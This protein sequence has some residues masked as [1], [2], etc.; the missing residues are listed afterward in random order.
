M[1][2]R[3]DEVIDP[4]RVDGHAEP[5]LRLDLVAFG[6]RD[7]THVVAEAGEL[8][9]ADLVP[10]A[11]ARA[12]DAMRATTAGLDAWPAT[13]LR[14]APRRVSTWPC[15]RSPWAA[16]LRFMKSMSIVAHGSSTLD[17]VCRW[18]SGFC[19]ALIP[20]IHIFAGENVCIQ[21]ITPT[22]VGSEFATRDATMDRRRF[23]EHGLELDREWDR[24]AIELVDDRRR[25]LGDLA[26]RRLSVQHL[27]AGEEPE[28]AIVRR[29]HRQTSFDSAG[30]HTRIV[31]GP[32]FP[33]S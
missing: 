11:A 20:L 18:S 4:V 1:R 2:R 16:W 8:E 13:V 12:Q 23:G 6:D 5:D 31:D 15:S 26:Q 33:Q 14:G 24:P 3:R 27:A 7:L 17:W 29:R 22:Q 21:V 30:I 25:L 28:P 9:G 19:R 10:A 32:R